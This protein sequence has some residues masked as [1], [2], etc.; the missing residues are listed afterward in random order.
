[1]STGNKRSYEAALADARA[2]RDLFDMLPAPLYE[3]WEFAGS[4]RRKRDQVGDVEHVIIPRFGDV[5]VEGDLFGGTKSANL[6]MH[7]LDELL[8][9]GQ[10]SKHLYGT[11]GFRWGDKNRGAD[12]R[13]FNHEL[14]MAD[15]DNWG[16]KLAILTG[17]ADF[18]KQLVTGLL[19]RERCNK[20]GYVWQ[21][22]AGE[23][24]KLPVA[25]ERQYFLL[26]GMA[27]VE[28]EDRA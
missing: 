14:F 4:L 21:C 8:K 5:T 27:W 22:H 18:S 25:N 11:T 16:S 6:V 13:G 2:F 12:F 1:M 26:A 24:Q 20:D 19:R 15:G 28:P 3:R 10:V 17:P 23:M 9:S 7:R